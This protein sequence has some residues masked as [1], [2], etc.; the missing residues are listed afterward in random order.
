MTAPYTTGTIHLENGSTNVT[1]IGTV[2]ETSLIVGGTIYVEFDGGNPLPI[3]TVN[4]DTD[5]IAAIKWTGPTGAY[6]Y[7][8][9]RDTSY[10][11][12][13]VRT[14]E[15][16]ATY[17][18]RL[19]NPALAATAGVVPGSNKILLFT[20]ANTA[21]VIDLEDLLQGVKFNEE[22]PTLADRAAYDGE[23]EGFRVLVAN[24]GDGRSA[25]FSKKSATAGDWSVPFYISGP[26]GNAGPY[27]DITIG[28]TETLPAGSEAEVTLVPVSPGVI[29]LD[30]G[31]P[32]GADGTGTGDFIGPDGDVAEN[33]FVVFGSVTGKVGKKAPNNSIPNRLLAQMPTATLK[34]RL[35]SGTGDSEDLTRAQ[36]RQLIGG[37]EPIGDPLNVA[38][39]ISVDWNNLSPFILLRME[40]CAQGNA[41][42][43]TPGF[44]MA[45]SEDNGATFIV[46]G[47]TYAAARVGA[48]GD[49]IGAASLV[50]M[51][52]FPVTFDPLAAASY[53]GF[54]Y[55]WSNW[56]KAGK[57][58]TVSGEADF[59]K[60]NN[61]RRWEKNFGFRTDN[62]NARN[63]LRF[64]SRDN[65]A[66]ANGRVQ[67]FG[68]RG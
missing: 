55:T 17:I 64:G 53:V 13:T 29:R 32:K 38:G 59:T 18:Q 44:Y 28:P 15:A 1:G 39:V 2:W 14:A 56:N 65:F 5:I 36:S 7:A 3:A 12:Q 43:A 4:S 33:D 23:V 16:L 66:F 9:M 8:I 57:H 50:N 42:A 40:G 47:A 54:T 58:T 48:E 68:I 34:G 46:G 45:V 51:G 63:A 22:V 24:V 62:T 31:L 25:F 41:G 21:T 30:F 11:Q 20:G 27:T 37:W 67:L 19:N 10:G 26:F 52:F 6:S 61:V 60:S 49:A 35:S